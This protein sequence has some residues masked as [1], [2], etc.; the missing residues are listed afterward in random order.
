MSNDLSYQSK[1]N[2]VRASFQ[3]CNLSG[4]QVSRFYN[5]SQNIPSVLEQEILGSDTVKHWCS[6]ARCS[7]FSFC[8][9]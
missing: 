9:I 2:R 8:L 3:Q 4:H 1:Q 5:I 7:P 6:R